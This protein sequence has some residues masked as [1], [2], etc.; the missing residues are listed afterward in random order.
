MANARWRLKA[1]IV[2]ERI[3]ET[4]SSSLAHLKK[5]GDSARAALGEEVE[6][7]GPFITW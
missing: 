6:V 1:G 7:P 4:Y 5:Y 2:M 3:S